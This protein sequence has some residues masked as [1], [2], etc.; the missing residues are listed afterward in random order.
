[1]NPYIKDILAD[2]GTAAEQCRR[3]LRE[4][5][6]KKQRVFITLEPSLVAAVDAEAERQ[7]RS[8]AAMIGVLLKKALADV[9]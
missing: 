5:A 4:D 8:R 1:M 7:D 3:W 6:M 9:K 2:D